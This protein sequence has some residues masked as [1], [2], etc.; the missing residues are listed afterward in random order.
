MNLE[1]ADYLRTPGKRVEWLVGPLEFYLCTA[2]E[3]WLCVVLNVGRWA[4][5]WEWRGRP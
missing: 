2:D 5:S 3:G 1:R 4:V